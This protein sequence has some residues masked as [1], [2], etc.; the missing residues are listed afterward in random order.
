MIRLRQTASNHEF[1]ILHFI[2]ILKTNP[3]EYW[4]STEATQQ[5]HGIQLFVQLHDGIY[6][7]VIAI[8]DFR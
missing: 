3:K 2:F 7:A 5:G 1:S 4:K 6:I 8:K